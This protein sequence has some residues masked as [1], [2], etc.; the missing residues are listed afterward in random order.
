MNDAYSLQCCLMGD[1]LFR[2]D[3]T[4]RIGIIISG[5]TTYEFQLAVRQGTWFANA[6]VFWQYL[7][8]LWNVSMPSSA[9][10]M[11]V[12]LDT[13]PDSANYRKVIITPDPG[14][15]TLT[16]TYFDVPGVYAD[17]GLP[18]QVYDM[19]SVYVPT[20]VGTLPYML[21]PVWPPVSYTRSVTN[22][23]GD[24]KKAHNGVTYSTAGATQESI[25]LALA[26]DRR[27][28]RFDEL[29]DFIELWRMRWVR[30]RAV[31]FY[32]DREN[33]PTA[34]QTTIGE[35]DVLV[36]SGH[37]DSI[38]FSR[39][40]PYV[41]FQD[42]LSEVTFAQRTPTPVTSEGQNYYILEQI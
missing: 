10:T 38:N 16:S 35:G 29:D 12:T 11:A 28:Q 24:V 6:L 34:H 32:L 26:L 19:G 9:G 7:I 23:T 42:V 40:V 17:V 37:Q 5:P 39:V 15:G 4:V 22:L 27:E 36:L 14:W 3:A 13:D 31:T 33:M 8:N 18:T 21:S 20:S 1:I 25:N 41:E 30:G 2:Q